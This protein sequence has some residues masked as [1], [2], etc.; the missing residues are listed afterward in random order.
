MNVGEETLAAQLKQAGI[1]HM[2]Q[3]R[4]APGRRF[5]AD[6]AVL[7]ARLLVE[8]QGGIYNRRAHGSI[9]GVLADMRRG[10]VAALAG[11][12]VLRVT[13]DEAA[14]GRAL[15]LIQRALSADG[16]R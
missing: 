6:F 9:T 16:E 4:Y 12:Y 13:P 11:W 1:A 8:V 10:N 15:A 14:D 7:D 3:Y 2:R 5:R